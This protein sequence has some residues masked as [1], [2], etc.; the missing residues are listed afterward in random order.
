MIAS[1]DQ[2]TFRQTL[3]RAFWIPFG[4]AVLLAATLILEVRFL[5]D[6]AAWVEQTDQVLTLAQRVYRNRIDQETGLRAYAL[7]GD[8]RFLEAFYE[9]RRQASAAEPELGRLVS[10][11]P[12][13]TARNEK[14]IQ[15]FEAW[16]SWADNAIAMMKAGENAGDVAFQLRGKELMDEY[17]HARTD[18]L[19]HEQQLR[20]ERL[21]RSR[22]TLE[23]VNASIVA[24]AILFGL[25]FAILGRKQLTSLSR[26]FV[27][28]LNLAEAN[29]DEAKSQRD[30]LH[31][32]VTSI[33]DA[34]I[35]TDAAGLIMLMNPVAEKLTGWMLTE[36]RGKPLADVFRIVNQETR[37]A[38]ENPVDK[39]RRLKRIVGLANHTILISR[40]GQEIAIDDSGAPI[41]GPDGALTGI[42]LV[43]RDVTEQRAAQRAIA[44]LAAIVEYSGDAIA[45]K[46]LDGIVQTWNAGAERLFGYKASEIIGKSVTVLIPPDRIN[47]EDEILQ[48]LHEGQPSGQLE[49]FRLGK[50]G[51]RIPVYVS[52][53]PIKDAEGRI[54]GASKVIHDITELAATREALVREKELLAT[55]LTSIGDA[56]IVTDAEGRL[57]FLNA[58]AER[59][60]AWKRSDAAGRP[61]PEV[62]RI[63]NEQTRQPVENPV[64][65]VLRLGAVVDLANHTLLLAKDGREIPIDD[66]AAP[67]REPDGPLFG[68][69]LVFRDFTERRRLEETLREG[70]QR[71][72]ASQ[73]RLLGLINSAMDAVI[74]VD[75]Q[76]RIVLFNPAAEKMFGCSVSEAKGESLDRFIPVRSRAAHRR[77][78]EDFGQ[79]GVTTRSM[80]RP[81]ALWGMRHNGD[82]F[83]IEATISQVEVGGQK[84]FTAILRD[85]TE[86]KKAET[87]L[88]EQASLLELT[89]D[90]I[91]VR[92]ESGHI[93][94]W[95]KGA[96]DLYGW[97][98]EEALGKVTHNL[99]RT[100][101][102]RPLA[103]IVDG[104]RKEKHWRGELVHTRRNGEQ[105]VVLSRWA[106]IYREQD[107]AGPR[108]L[109]EINTD[110]TRSKQLEAALQS[111]ERLALAGRLSAS[112]AH[113]IHNPLDT[114]ANALFLID[115]RIDG[116]PGIR[117]LVATAQS[118]VQRVADISKN[119]LSLHRE[120][121]AASP[122]KLSE[123]LKGVVTLIEETITKGRRNIELVPGYEGDVEAFPSELRQVFT[124]VIK[125]AVEATAEG[126]EIKIYSEAA[127]ESAQDGVLVRVVDNGVGI[128][129]QVQSKLFSPFVTTKEE[130]G[131]GLGLWVSRMI[132]E[133]HGGSIRLSSGSEPEHRGTTVS[134]FL[135]LKVSSQKTAELSS[136]TRA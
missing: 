10:D 11:N 125:N 82:E 70:V 96:E 97:T 90:A 88:T 133:K 91:I 4:I 83:P 28:V 92:D 117:Q 2:K 21:A 130:T 71:A 25:G 3:R 14:S 12:D 69:V 26:S 98:Q 54:V 72:T 49:T 65:K 126:E 120:S 123:L 116:Q 79:T 85:I 89:S 31:T 129:E 95:N 80:S 87:K 68:V 20:D 46:N 23:F 122:V 32:T 136:T 102:P 45:T 113:E 57:T 67:I 61:L 93:A 58:E 18:F 53:S 43:F 34:V 7:T 101:F 124:N 75:A 9:G 55:T 121:R 78:I 86:R 119:M 84:I 44:R 94:Y 19:D 50:D 66:S 81:G 35:A 41:F 132:L 48:H 118:E 74:A 104:V 37:L 36:A 109:M 114:V 15:A 110:V 17:R 51:R 16:S 112:I 13:Q 115:Q 47:D 59:L 56:V 29:A 63:V 108:S 39:V 107:A 131:T 6:R 5:T 38:V 42:V 134:I 128:P 8:T 27:K 62:F 76:Q 64:E 33:G 99:L 40:S 135:P 106:L 100:K 1:M 30:W 105:V 60:T 127:Q 73:E 77:H 52:V 24:L 103:E 22:R 111:N